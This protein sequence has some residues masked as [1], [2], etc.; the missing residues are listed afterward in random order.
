MGQIPVHSLGY[1]LPVLSGGQ[2]WL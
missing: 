1:G 2:A